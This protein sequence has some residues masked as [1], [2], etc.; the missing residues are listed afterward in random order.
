MFETE[1]LVP[2]TDSVGTEIGTNSHFKSFAYHIKH[3]CTL[4]K[5]NQNTRFRF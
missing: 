2:R 4:N 3:T 5:F 1:I